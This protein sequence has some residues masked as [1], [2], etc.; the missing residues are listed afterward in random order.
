M[1]SR[2]FIDFLNCIYYNSLCI[3]LLTV[4]SIISNYFINC[5]TAD[6]PPS[7]VCAAGD[8]IAPDISLS[9]IKVAREIVYEGDRPIIWTINIPSDT[10][11]QE[12]ARVLPLLLS[13]VTLAFS[14][15]VVN[16]I[17]DRFVINMTL[18]SG[19]R[20]YILTFTSKGIVDSTEFANVEV[21]QF[22][23]EVTGRYSHNWDREFGR[24]YSYALFLKELMAG[25]I[26]GESNILNNVV[27]LQLQYNSKDNTS[28]FHNVRLKM[29]HTPLELSP[30][31]SSLS[32][33][34]SSELVGWNSSCPE[35][36]GGFRCYACKEGYRGRPRI[37]I[38][39][40]KCMCNGHSTRCHRRSG[41]CFNCADNTVGR[42]CERCAKG[43]VGDAVGGVCERELLLM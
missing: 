22:N 7:R 18:A 28:R 10:N 27:S 17:G 26:I 25:D 9:S 34:L 20:R 6:P 31:N 12:Y 42:H 3:Q 23:A 29:N 19:N 32:F 33:N 37:G 11:P 4:T 2:L 21:L 14:S 1:I 8:I 36:S 5:T 13:P 43:Y 41:R 30:D 16:I 24:N 39:C 15:D 40:R 38:P 35:G